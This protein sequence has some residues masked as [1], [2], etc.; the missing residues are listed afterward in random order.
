MDAGNPGR[1]GVSAQELSSPLKTLTSSVLTSETRMPVGT[2]IRA[3][4]K[5][6][7]FYQNTGT[8]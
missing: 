6:S 4:D 8:I 7:V 2:G 5:I 1:E 3:V